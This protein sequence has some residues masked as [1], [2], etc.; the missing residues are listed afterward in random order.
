MA[1][2]QNSGYRQWLGAST[3]SLSVFTIFPLSKKVYDLDQWL[4]EGDKR[5]NKDVF[6]D[7][8]YLV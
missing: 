7:D 5:P 8:A 2:K 4:Q 1:E 3:Q 6:K